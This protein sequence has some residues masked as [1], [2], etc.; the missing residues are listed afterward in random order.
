MEQVPKDGLPLKGRAIVYRDGLP[1][2]LGVVE[3]ADES[4]VFLRLAGTPIGSDR[5]VSIELCERPRDRRWL[6]GVVVEENEQGIDVRFSG[7]A[8]DRDRPGRL[9]AAGV[10][11]T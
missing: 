2:A 9:S 1:A 6:T 4:G 3:S 11:T 8:E 5:R 10:A 7:D